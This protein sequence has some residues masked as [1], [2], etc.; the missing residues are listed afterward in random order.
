ML[1]SLHS[2]RSTKGGDHE[3]AAVMAAHRDP[4]GG[5]F[6]WGLTKRKLSGKV[7]YMNTN[8]YLTG[9]AD[10]E[11]GNTIPALTLEDFIRDIEDPAEARQSF[12]DDMRGF[13]GE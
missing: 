7:E 5:L 9:K 2:I 10:R 1:G 4:S 11:I 8:W 13:N 6:I 12:D 3:Q